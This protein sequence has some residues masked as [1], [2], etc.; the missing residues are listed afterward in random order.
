M[1]PVEKKLVCALVLSSSKLWLYEECG[2]V[3][4]LGAWRSQKLKSMQE[5][6][7]GFRT[8]QWSDQQ[9]VDYTLSALSSP[10]VESATEYVPREL[11]V[12]WNQPIRFYFLKLLV[13]NMLHSTVQSVS[14]VIRGRIQ[15]PLG[16][17]LSILAISE[18]AYLR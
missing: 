2:G 18:A 13:Y 9:A 7:Q 10:T 3:Q 1:S 15:Y 5:T 8:N 14:I 16:F 4:M 6:N 11:V 17:I 12:T